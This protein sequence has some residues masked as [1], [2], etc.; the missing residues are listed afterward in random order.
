MEKILLV[1]KNTSFSEKLFLK[2]RDQKDHNIFWE[3]DLE[4][5]S[6]INPD[7]IVIFHWPN[8]I[9]KTI[10]TKFKCITVHTGNLPDDR[11]GSP[12]Q[13][14]ILRGKKFSKVNLIEVS[15]PVDSGRIYC[16]KEISLQGSLDDIW[17]VITESTIILLNDFLNKKMDPIPQQGKPQSFKRKTDNK[18]QLNNIE[19]IYDQI[20]MLDGE[21]Y[22][23]SFIEVEGFR[24]E[25]RNSRL[26]NNEIEAL[27]RIK[28]I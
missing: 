18:I 15:D 7:L 8:I 22:P 26:N 28:K 6:D 2:L 14:Q 19:S 5:I 23:K 21:G 16:S 25:F 9:S 10:Y 12:I 4:K 13:N 1:S 17:N 24:F 11:G 27:V 3:N 20:R